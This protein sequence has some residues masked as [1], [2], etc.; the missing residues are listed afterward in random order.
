MMAFDPRSGG[1][2]DFD[3]CQGD[4]FEAGN[5]V[6]FGHVVRRFVAARC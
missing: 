2:R 4:V 5:E 6:F 3:L 1:V